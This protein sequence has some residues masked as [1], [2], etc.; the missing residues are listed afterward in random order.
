MSKVPDT[1]AGH[2]AVERSRAAAPSW[3]PVLALRPGPRVLARVF[4]PRACR[5]GAAS[6][7]A[8][9]AAHRLCE[10]VLVR[11]FLWSCRLVVA[12]A[13]G[14]MRH[15]RR[16]ADAT[17][18]RPLVDPAALVPRLALVVRSAPVRCAAHLEPWGHGSGCTHATRAES[19][20]RLRVGRMRPAVSDAA[21]RRVG[22]KG[23]RSG[24]HAP[25]RHPSGAEGPRAVRIDSSGRSGGCWTR[26]RH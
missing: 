16:A 8:V 17:C 4:W 22:A 10:A 20:S 11:P 9:R 26:F 23:K 7:L 15:R 14:R 24:A 12:D 1:K 3:P 13:T 18:G 19:G 21:R 5:G 2:A 25:E 6:P